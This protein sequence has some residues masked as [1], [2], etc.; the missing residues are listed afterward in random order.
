MSGSKYILYNARKDGQY[1]FND[2]TSKEPDARSQKSKADD[3]AE[4]H[5]SASEG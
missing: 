4:T 5:R 2:I 1:I 3:K